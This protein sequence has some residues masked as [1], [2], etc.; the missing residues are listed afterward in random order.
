MTRLSSMAREEEEEP[1]G[2]PILVTEPVENIEEEDRNTYTAELQVDEPTQLLVTSPS[3]SPIR[4]P[5]IPSFSEFVNRRKMK[6]STEGSDGKKPS[7]VMK[8]Q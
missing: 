4:L 6:H 5:E 1:S 7:K 3:R 2:E 8:L